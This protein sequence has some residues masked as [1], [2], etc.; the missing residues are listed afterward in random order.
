MVTVLN[1]TI[2]QPY[3]LEV[4]VNGQTVGYVANEDVFNSPTRR[5]RSVSTTPAPTTPSG[6]W[7]LPTPLPWPT[8][9]WTKTRWPNA[10]LK[11]A[12]DQISEGTALYL[13]GELTAV[14]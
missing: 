6:P 1:N 3:A 12:S 10:I 8:R 13:D 9:P 14:C 7:N 4:Q 5:C 11:S 2:R